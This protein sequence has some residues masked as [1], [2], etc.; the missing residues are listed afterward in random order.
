MVDAFEAGRAG[1][2]TLADP[3]VLLDFA[4]VD[5]SCPPY[6]LREVPMAGSSGSQTA[7]Q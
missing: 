6:G 5:V 1:L 2:S 4:I 3:A 7:R